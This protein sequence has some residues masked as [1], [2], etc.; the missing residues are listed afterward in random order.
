[1]CRPTCRQDIN[2]HK[3]NKTLREVHNIKK[4]K[5]R[6]KESRGK[7][8]PVTASAFLPSLARVLIG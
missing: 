5:R 2:I 8:F 4:R 3:R 1:V 6:R 7:R